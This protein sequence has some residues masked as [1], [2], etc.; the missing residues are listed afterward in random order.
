MKVCPNCKNNVEDNAV[1]CVVCGTNVASSQ[2][3]PPVVEYVQQTQPQ[4]QMPPQGA[5]QVPPQGA[6]NYTVPPVSQPTVD[7][8]D[9]TGE[10]DAKDIE[11]NKMYALLVYL[12]SVLG[13]VIAML[14][15]KDSRYLEFHIKQGLKL[16]IAET[17]VG[18]ATAL[19]CWTC[20]VPVAGSIA[21][22]ALTV[23]QI[24]CIIDVCQG[25]AKVAPIIRS[26][27]FLDSL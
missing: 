8:F 2:S 16:V 15:K 1:F 20:I 17:I 4:S 18:I 12:L 21:L 27:K 14:V 7:Q 25:K 11:E 23:V 26:I 6:P 22:I 19:L 13:I 3:E 24:I 10:F 5:Q 9:H